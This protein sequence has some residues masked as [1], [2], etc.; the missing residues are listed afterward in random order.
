M[1]SLSQVVNGHSVTVR[2]VA[3][4]D[5]RTARQLEAFGILPGRVLVV[6]RAAPFGGPVM[7]RLGSSRYA[8]GRTVC[9]RILVEP[10]AV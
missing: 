7:V 3:L 6:E 4:A 8:L 10:E 5:V 1:V 2:M 9:D